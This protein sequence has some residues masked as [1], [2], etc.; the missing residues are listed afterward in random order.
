MEKDR[1]ASA[2]TIAGQQTGK[3]L[4]ASCVCSGTLC[5]QHFDQAV[6]S[7]CI[8]GS[9]KRLGATFMH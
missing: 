6:H 8:S 3:R 1:D 9:A 5:M 2:S 4:S 7:T